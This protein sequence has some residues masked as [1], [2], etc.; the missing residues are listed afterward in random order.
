M[1]Y[2]YSVIVTNKKQNAKRVMECHQGRGSQEGLFAELKSQAQMDY[3]P[4]Q[5]QAGNHMYMLCAVMAHSL[6]RELQVKTK[7]RTRKTNAKREDFWVFDS[8]N[9]VRNTI[10]IH[11]GRLIRPNGHFVLSMNSNDVLKEEIEKYFACL[12]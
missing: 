6:N 8:I 10:F 12:N 11:A 7:K 5:R 9:R 2:T 1:G 3:I 4:V